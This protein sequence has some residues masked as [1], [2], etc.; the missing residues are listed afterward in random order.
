VERAVDGLADRAA[1][2]RLVE[3][4]ARRQAAG[5][6]DA[7]GG[8]LDTNVDPSSTMQVVNALIKANKQFD[9]LVMP[10]EDHPPAAA[11]PARLTA[12]ARCG[13]SSCDTCW[14]RRRRIG[15]RCRRRRPHGVC[16][17]SASSIT[18]GRG[19]EVRSKSRSQSHD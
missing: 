6:V 13:T 3:R 1:V 8:E 4:D 10:G 9:L 5:Q 19:F 18:A 16:R 17:L 15:T 2:R 14:D 12:I 7:R 11:A